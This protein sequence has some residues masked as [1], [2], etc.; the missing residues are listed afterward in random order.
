MLSWRRSEPRP[1][2]RALLGCCLR[3]HLPF[4]TQVRRG[5]EDT[6]LPTGWLTS[7]RSLSGARAAAGSLVCL[8]THVL[9]HMGQADER[10]CPGCFRVGVDGRCDDSSS[11]LQPHWW[12][13]A[14]W[15][16]SQQLR[17][18]NKTSCLFSPSCHLG[19][20]SGPVRLELVSARDPAVPVTLLVAPVRDEP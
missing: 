9:P 8:I 18:I 11:D 2:L 7:C 4:R 15:R 14:E 19:W 6:S 1:P 10:W 12:T 3:D 5:Q 17:P 20:W 13:S 16:L